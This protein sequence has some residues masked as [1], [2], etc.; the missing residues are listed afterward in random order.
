MKLFENHFEDYIHAVND[1]NL[2]PGVLS[3]LPTPDRIQDLNHCIFYGPSGVGKYSQL[4]AY[5]QHY[6]PTQLKYDKRMVVE[7]E[8]ANFVYRIS[9]IHYEI[10]FRLLGCNPKQLWHEIYNQIVDI[11]SVKES[12]CGIIVCKDFHTIHS[13]LLELFYSY[14]QQHN[15]PSSPIQIKFMLLTEHVGFLP[16]AIIDTFICISWRRPSRENYMAKWKH[17]SNNANPETLASLEPC[18]ILNLKEMSSFSYIK[19]PDNMPVDAFNVICDAIIEQM[20]HLNRLNLITFRDTL[21]DIFIYHLDVQECIWTIL[22][23]WI[24]HDAFTTESLL[25][26]SETLSEQIKQYNNNYR[27]IYH[28]ESMFLFMM[29]HFV[30]A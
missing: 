26:I 11:I 20:R 25:C 6:S 27:P 16:D 8:K 7:T 30:F 24:R 4:L 18:Q 14:V 15:H 28:L 5:I 12:K 10:D 13:E 29:K 23:Y 19:S 2:H 17:D 3:R 21:Y 1:C 9:D 22:A